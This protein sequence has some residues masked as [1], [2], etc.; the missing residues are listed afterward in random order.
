MERRNLNIVL[1]IILVT[2]NIFSSKLR[3]EGASETS[4]NIYQIT[5]SH[6]PKYSN[7]RNH[8]CELQQFPM[9]IMPLDT[10]LRLSLWMFV[11]LRTTC[12]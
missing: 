1:G 5:R 6:I 11:I 3:M 4:A 10:S 2:K 9:C 8:H 12:Y 7:L